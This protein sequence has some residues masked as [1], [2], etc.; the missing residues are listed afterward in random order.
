M[1]RQNL[2]IKNIYIIFSLRDGQG[3][4]TLKGSLSKELEVLFYFFVFDLITPILKVLYDP[5]RF[6]PSN[7]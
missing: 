6:T 3:I 5:Y 7:E 4:T 2:A 1:L